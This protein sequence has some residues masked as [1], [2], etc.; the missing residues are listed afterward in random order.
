MAKVTDKPITVASDM[1]YAAT[2]ASAAAM[3]MALTWLAVGA[4][5]DRWY[6]ALRRPRFAL[7]DDWQMAGW[8]FA[9][10]VI[11]F[12]L[13]RVLRVD[14]PAWQRD[15]RYGAAS[16]VI[17]LAVCASWAWLTYSA[18]NPLLAM[19]A[20]FAAVLIASATLLLCGRANPFAAMC[21]V[22][23][24]FWICFQAVVSVAAWHLN[25]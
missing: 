1:T 25:G 15:R 6:A 3:A 10:A 2:A 7:S 4:D 13:W 11:G 17:L 9:Y 20:M 22:P 12:A 21:L 8:V 23:P 18:R 24:F 16:A 5:V 14:A 19:F